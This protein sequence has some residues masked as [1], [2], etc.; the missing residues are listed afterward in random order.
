MKEPACEQKLEN[1]QAW[2]TEHK[3]LAESEID[4]EKDIL[5]YRSVHWNDYRL[6]RSV[7]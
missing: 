1:V 7:D 4:D 2:G 5:S 6:G 3:A